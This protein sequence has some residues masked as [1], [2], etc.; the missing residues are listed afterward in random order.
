MPQ[1]PKTYKP[2]NDLIQLNIYFSS[3]R[4]H[5]ISTRDW[6]SDGCSSDLALVAV[7]W[8][9]TMPQVP[10]AAAVAASATVALFTGRAEPTAV[11]LALLGSVA[12]LAAPTM[13]R[14]GV[15]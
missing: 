3:R 1:K 7:T 4:L 13:S 12:V 15:A 5:T 6:S 9:V 2:V 11:A 10:Q 14:R 8:L